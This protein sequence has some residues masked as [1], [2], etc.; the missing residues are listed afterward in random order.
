MT[1]EMA[2]KEIPKEMLSLAGEYAVASE[3]CRRGHY[4]QLTLGT[5][6]KTDILVDTGTAMLRVQVKSKQGYAWVCS[7][8]FG[9]NIIL[10]LVDYADRQLDQ[11]PDFYILTTRDWANFL[12]VPWVKERIAEGTVKIDSE[13]RPIW[14]SKGKSTFRGFRV[15]PEEIAKHKEKW[16]K[17]EALLNK[18]K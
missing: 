10:V 7:G 12:K 1:E 4:A 17:I 6:K 9:E 8:V 18:K 3:L 11:R 15:E 16:S 14:N 13:N 2:A 5:R